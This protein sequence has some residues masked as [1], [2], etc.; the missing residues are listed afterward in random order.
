VSCRVCAARCYKAN[1]KKKIGRFLTK[2][3]KGEKVRPVLLA[4]H[5]AS[6]LITSMAAPKQ[7]SWRAERVDGITFIKDVPGVRKRST[8][9]DMATTTMPHTFLLEVGND[10]LQWPSST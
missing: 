7:Y 6:Q 3:G 8:V 5:Q 4:P 2:G 9:C 10:P 1:V